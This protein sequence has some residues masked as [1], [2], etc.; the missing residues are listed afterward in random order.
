MDS[1]GASQWVCWGWR[2]KPGMHPRKQPFLRRDGQG[3]QAEAEDMGLTPTS[4]WVGL[5]RRLTPPSPSKAK[6][7]DGLSLIPNALQSNE[8]FQGGRSPNEFQALELGPLP[9]SGFNHSLHRLMNQ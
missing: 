7:R 9:T 2:E 1:P 6:V 5:T 4:R 8:N 3:S